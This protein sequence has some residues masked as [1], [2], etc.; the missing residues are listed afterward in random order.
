MINIGFAPTMS[1]KAS[2]RPSTAAMTSADEADAICRLS[3][4]YLTA[5]L[6]MPE[7]VDALFTHSGLNNQQEEK[8]SDHLGKPTMR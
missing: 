2:A 3:C 5:F 8:T 7:T 4:L 1:K 6:Y